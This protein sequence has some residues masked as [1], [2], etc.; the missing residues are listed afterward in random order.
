MAN[1][2]PILKDYPVKINNTAIP[3]GG[4]MS[5]EFSD[6]ETVNV[7][8]AG[9]DIVQ[10]ERHGKLTFTLNFQTFSDWMQT[11]ESWYLDNTVKTVSIYSFATGAY[12]DY[13]MRMRDYKPVLVEDTEKLKQTT[14][15]WKIS[16]KLIEM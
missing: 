10:T 15:V 8:E 5:Q 9:T 16:F 2:I 12:K 4:T 13:S 14:G 7:S 6:V 1:T 11:L 3:Y